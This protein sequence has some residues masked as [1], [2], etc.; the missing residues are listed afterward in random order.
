MNFFT[1]IIAAFLWV[2]VVLGLWIAAAG[3]AHMLTYAQ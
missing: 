3:L 1:E 2:I